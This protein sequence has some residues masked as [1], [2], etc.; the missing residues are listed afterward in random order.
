M[1]K[2]EDIQSSL[3]SQSTI[4]FLNKITVVILILAV[5]S[6]YFFYRHYFQGKKQINNQTQSDQ[7]EIK[8]VVNAIGKLMLLPQNEQPTLATVSDKTKLQNQSFFARAENGDKVLIYTNAKKAIL[9]RPSINKII[10]V[11]PVNVQTPQETPS[12]T[13]AVPATPTVNPTKTQTVKIAIYNGTKTSGL[14]A[15]TEKQLKERLANIDVVLKTNAKSDYTKT[16]IVD[17]TGTN[18]ETVQQVVTLLGGDSGSLPANETKPEADILIIL[19][20]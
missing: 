10:E 1:K 12:P 14:A 16:I 9:Y 4:K 17:L 15:T 18:K 20:K 5:L 11:A 3:Q 2:K 13:T 7:N 6:G 8:S 19:G